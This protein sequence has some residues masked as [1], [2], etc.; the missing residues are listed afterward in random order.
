M[1]SKNALFWLFILI[2]L[3]V[4]LHPGY[5]AQA[6][7]PNAPRTNVTAYDLIAAMNT[8]RVSNGFPALV[9]D[10]I[11]NAVAQGTADIM[12]ANLMSWHIG[13][14]RGR[15]A[16]A[17]YGGGG[18]V[19]AT[20]NFA[21]GY[22]MSIDE[23]MVAWADPDHMRPAVNGAYCHVGAGV[24]TAS[25]GMIYYILQAAYVSGKSCGTY[26]SPGT[27][28]GSGSS[29]GGGSSVV[30]GIIVPVKVAEPGED[31]RTYHIVKSGQSLWAIAIAYHVTIADL[32]KFNNISRGTPLKVGQQLFIPNINTEGY[33]TPTPVGMIVP[34]EPDAEGKVIHTVA[35]YQTLITISTAYSTTVNTI[36]QL[37]NW[38]EDWPLQIGQK[39][40]IN[41]GN[42]TPSPTPRP[43]TPIEKL[44]PAADGSYYH[45]VQS[46]ETLSW[47]AD[48]YEISV[49]E[50]MTW[51]GLYDS[52]IRADQE[53]LL[54]VTPPATITNTPRPPTIT[55][56]ITLT[57]VPPTAS[58]TS[59]PAAT[60]VPTTA[61][62]EQNGWFSSGWPYFAGGLIAVGLVLLGIYSRKK[63]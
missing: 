42:V 24:S 39:L 15:I 4:S 31:G 12:A 46:G 34:A 11:V 44:T 59:K 52:N 7:P 30:W 5:R 18:Q 10:P 32:E 60:A 43:L 40:M 13:D 38:Q 49:N 33:A 23:I 41:L 47:I 9:E 2:I 16:A 26:T 25:N 6:R 14:V 61:V 56:T 21:M 20:E 54:K 58:P 17:G 8:L 37:N 62:E 27:G 50:L 22:T 19:W 51:N 1:R 55:P 45:V 35:A 48:L 29:E 28:P 53:L 63:Q 57:P 3:A 36:L